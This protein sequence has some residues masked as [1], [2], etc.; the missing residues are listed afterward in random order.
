MELGGDPPVSMAP[1]RIKLKLEA[2]PVRCCSRRYSTVHR[3][4]LANHVKMLLDA[5]LC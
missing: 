4:F 1:I 2:T 3:N 5:G